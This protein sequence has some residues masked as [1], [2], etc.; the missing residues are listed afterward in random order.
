MTKKTINIFGTSFLDLI[1]G[2]LAAVIILFV[3]VPKKTQQEINQLE[4]V[5]QLEQKVI[6]IHEAIERIE[7]SV[8]FDEYRQVQKQLDSIDNQLEQLSEQL[9][10][11]E[12]IVSELQEDNRQQAL[13][14]AE[15]ERLIGELQQALEDIKQEQQ[16]VERTA[17]TIETTLGVFAEF[18]IIC[19]W[20]DPN[21][22]V[23]LGIQRFGANPEQCW[24]NYPSKPWG[25]LGEDVRE[26]DNDGTERFELFYVPNIYPGEYT[27]WVDVYT[28][29]RGGSTTVN[30]TLIFHPGKQDEKRIEIPPFTVTKQAYSFIATFQLSKYD[31]EILNHR[32]PVW[33]NGVT[34]K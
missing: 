30:S 27:A 14:I 31:V 17:N 11:T 3:I 21:V 12:Q 20:N 24:R 8:S 1:S 28:G 10:E 29:S 2:A 18:G 32:E 4:Q 6:D 13:Q 26:R 5:H 25:I 7:H 22:D 19:R 33:G 34:I 23:D 15:Q 9:Q 16:D